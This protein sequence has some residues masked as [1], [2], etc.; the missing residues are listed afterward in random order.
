MK[1]KKN[2]LVIFTTQD[3]EVKLDV[4][5]SEETVWLNLNQMAELFDRDKSTITRHIK[6]ALSEE[7]DRESTVANFATAQIEGHRSICSRSILSF[8]MN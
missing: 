7:V 6:N 2:E 8:V 4:N 3:G 1:E 5:M